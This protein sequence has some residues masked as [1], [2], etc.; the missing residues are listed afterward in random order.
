MSVYLGYNLTQK[1]YTCVN[2]MQKTEMQKRRK[3]FFC[4]INNLCRKMQ[5][6]S[7]ICRY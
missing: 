3:Y 5:K 7:C 2:I 6:V 4:I 1:F